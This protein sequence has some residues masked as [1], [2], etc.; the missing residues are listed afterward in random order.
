MI[1]LEE[2]RMAIVSADTDVARTL[3]EK[4]LKVGVPVSDILNKGLIPGLHEVGS[5]FE[6][7]NYFLPELICS[8][9][10]VA[11]AL[12]ILEP[13]LRKE[14]APRIGK[15]VIGTVER[16]IH[17]LGKNIVIM[18]LRGNGWEVTD[19]GVDVSPQEFCSAVAKG[20]YQMLGMSRSRSTACWMG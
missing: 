1:D 6:D 13:L 20:D 7:G 16:D 9:D 12:E 14:D 3:T 5:L 18:M 17:N 15:Y 4:A 11:R 19:L 10:A 2:L 8:G